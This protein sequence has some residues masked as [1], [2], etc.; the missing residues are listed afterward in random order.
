MRSIDRV[1]TGDGHAQADVGVGELGAYVGDEARLAGAAWADHADRVIVRDCGERS[2]LVA[3][4]PGKVVEGDVV[5]G[6]LAEVAAW[7]KDA[8]GGDQLDQ[9]DGHVGR[10]GR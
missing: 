10:A 3:R 8:S 6:E 5:G 7:P 9:L 4:V 1:G 2:A